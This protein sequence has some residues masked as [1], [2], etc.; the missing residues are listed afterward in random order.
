MTPRLSIV[1]PIYNVEPYVGDCL[2]SLARQTFR[3]FEVVLV[4]DGSPDGSA[5]I[6]R[7]FCARD[8]RFRLVSQENQGLGPARNTGV[9]HSQGEY[10]TFV[11]SDDL[12]PRHAYEIMVRSLDETSSSLAAGNARR[13]NNTAGV[14]QSYVHKIPFARDRPATHVFDFPALAL[15]RMAW[16]KVY[17]R[18]FFDQFRYEFP[19]I[20]YEDYPISLR[21]H[22][23][24]V[25]VDVLS[26][27]V[28]YWRERESG[29]SITQQKFRHGNL[30]DRV[31]SAE[32]VLDVLDQRAPELRTLV[33]EHFAVVDLATVV[34]AFGTAAEHETAPLLELGRRLTRR[35]DPAVLGAVA[36]FQRLEY[37]A[38]QTGDIDLLQRLAQFRA[39]GGLRGGVRAQ[40]HPVL[41]W[42]YES[43]YPGLR[44]GSRVPAALYRLPRHELDLRTSVSAVG[45]DDDAL[46][47]RGTAEIH[48]LATEETSSL[49][50][51]LSCAGRTT[52]LAVERFTEP[53]SHG[54]S[55]LVG[56]AAR[57]PRTLLSTLPAT[58]QAAYV[59]VDLRTA[60]VRRR[61]PLLA[62]SLQ[63]PTGDRVDDV[64]IQPART[65]DGRFMLQRLTDPAELTSAEVDGPDL[66]LGG[67]LP[68]GSTAPALHL[69]RS[70]GEVQVPL[71]RHGTT[72]FTARVPLDTLVDEVNPDD[73][74]LERTVLVPRVVDGAAKALL[75]VSGLR[76][77]VG[78]PHGNRLVTVT[79][80]PGQYLNLID[81]PV[82]VTADRID[83]AVD[84]S[85][86]TVSGPRWPGVS[87]EQIRWR[88]FLADSDEPV[89]A[90][91]RTTRTDDRWSA[92][93]DLD[94]LLPATDAPTWT[95]FAAGGPTA[96]A[97]QVDAFLL[98]R[99]PPRV[100]GF[101]LRPRS[102]ILH[103]ETS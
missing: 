62:G 26:A 12:V 86:L 23:D 65:D 9:R 70:A 74:F 42:R 16:N 45:W 97:V 21:S 33:H 41:P 75:L 47:V 66:V 61:G 13:F 85:R 63:Y 60:G 91:D 38:L 20:R 68:A 1:V 87:Y 58:A 3:D 69:A 31:V 25:T 49:R 27:P 76:Q 54:K 88:R 79:R 18:T 98:G 99:L 89:D 103:L 90:P 73:P 32:M 94:D 80:S 67:R 28:Y 39:D 14:R 37:N 82:R 44:D 40:R 24:A 53:D 64:W 48:H 8:D 15:D 11:D 6:A 36:T 93:L 95:L 84:G 55:R 92:E 43:R 51:S 22:L 83:A 101:Y 34:Q 7:A 72:G 35:L 96:Y 52:K 100:G 29:E 50:L 57:I 4:D 46:T 81:G 19:A 10:L 102:G 59:T 5:D 2:D 71:Q 56:F 78:A 77:A 17:R 30:L